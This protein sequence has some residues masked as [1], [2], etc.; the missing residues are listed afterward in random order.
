MTQTAELSNSEIVAET[1][2]AIRVRELTRVGQVR[3][4]MAELFPQIDAE[5]R[6]ECLVELANVLCSANA[7]VLAPAQRRRLGRR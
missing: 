5:R 4:V 7:E 1:F 2:Q 3:D 6:Q